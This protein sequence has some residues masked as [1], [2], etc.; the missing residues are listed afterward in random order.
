DRSS[1]D[2]DPSQYFFYPKAAASYRIPSLKKGLIDE[3]KLRAAFGESGNQPLW[4]QK[5][6][7]L[8]TNIISNSGGFILPT[9][10][11]ANKIVPERQ[12]ETEGGVDA[13]L[14]DGRAN[15]E[16]TGYQ[17]MISDLLLNRTLAPSTGFSN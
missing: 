11:G 6:T 3:L 4:G 13:A 17:K 12:A 2:G 5:T 15:L 14:F 7:L 9:Q 16:I 8:T 1:N 10:A